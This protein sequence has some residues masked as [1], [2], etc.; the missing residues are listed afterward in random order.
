MASASPTTKR[1]LPPYLAVVPAP[2][3]RFR[4]PKAAKPKPPSDPRL[5]ALPRT[6]EHAEEVMQRL[7]QAVYEKDHLVVAALITRASVEVSYARTLARDLSG[8]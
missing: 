7:V 2:G 1:A 5:D 4:K 8:A 6:H 3:K